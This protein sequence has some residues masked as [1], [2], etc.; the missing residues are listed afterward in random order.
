[1]EGQARTIGKCFVDLEGVES[2]EHPGEGK[3]F[4]SGT[5]G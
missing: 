4:L 1:M 2:E 5:S 3:S